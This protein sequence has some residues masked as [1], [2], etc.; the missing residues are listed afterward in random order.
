MTKAPELLEYAQGLAF[1]GDTAYDSSP[2]AHQIEQKGMQVVIGPAAVPPQIS[3]G[4]K[5][6]LMPLLMRRSLTAARTRM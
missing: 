4:E 3:G 2:L 5:P 6:R 1:L